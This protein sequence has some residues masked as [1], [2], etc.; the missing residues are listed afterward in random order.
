MEAA[1]GRIR[2]VLADER[3]LPM[4]NNQRMSNVQ[5]RMARGEPTGVEHLLLELGHSFVIMA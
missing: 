5:G 3:K 4:T 2:E 1:Q